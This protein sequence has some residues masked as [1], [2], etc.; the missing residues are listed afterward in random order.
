[1]QIAICDDDSSILNQL[2]SAIEAYGNQHKS[3]FNITAF[4]CAEDLLDT[5]KHFDILFLDIY[6]DGMT[7]IEAI[8][9][10][11]HER[12]DCV[13]F[14]TSSRDYAVDAYQLDAVHYL[15]K[16][17]TNDDIYEA[18][19]RCY[20]RLRSHDE[21]VLNISGLISIP[22]KYI[23][24]IEAS[25]KRTIIYTDTKEYTT[26]DT[27]DKIYSCLDSK[28]FMRAQ[29]SYI[30]HMGK[31]KNFYYDH[32]VLEDGLIIS[33]SRKQQNMLKQQYK[34]YLLNLARRTV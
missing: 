27:L 10:I 19:D 6:M 28:I 3:T 18:L 15:V 25:N 22:Y 26:Y 14:L 24:Y 31:I 29:R 34:T 33:L 8:R 2:T 20:F 23:S 17:V 30:V 21:P 9:R 32:I 13:V 16:P 11:E 5:K 4:T 12:I 7:G 1:M